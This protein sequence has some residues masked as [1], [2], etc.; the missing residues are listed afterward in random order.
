MKHRLTAVTLSLFMLIS[1]LCISSYALADGPDPTPMATFIKNIPDSDDS[2]YMGTG[3]SWPLEARIE[4]ANESDVGTVTYQWYCA[5]GK[6]PEEADFAPHDASVTADEI[7]ST[8][9]STGNFYRDTTVGGIFT[10]YVVFTNT[11]DNVTTT[12]ESNHRTTYITP[13]VLWAK[14]HNY[15]D[16]TVYYYFQGSPAA[17]L[18]VT[19][20]LRNDTSEYADENNY[21]TIKYQW[22]KSNVASSP[23]VYDDFPFFDESETPAVPGADGEITYQ[24]A[25][26]GL[27]VTHTPV[28]NVV[29][30]FNYFVFVYDELNGAISYTPN[31]L[32]AVIEV[33]PSPVASIT[34]YKTTA[35]V[36]LSVILPEGLSVEPEFKYLL[37]EKDVDPG[38]DPAYNT[39]TLTEA[40]AT[41]T[42]EQ[43]TQQRIYD[44]YL[45]FTDNENTTWPYKARIRAYSD[46][47]G[48][49]GSTTTTGGNAIDAGT[50]DGEIIAGGTM[51]QTSTG[52]TVTIT[53]GSFAAMASH[54][55]QTG[56]SVQINTDTAVVSFDATAVGYIN[57]LAGTDD[58]SLQINQAD[59]SGLSAEDQALIGDRPV[60]DFTLTAGG[61]QVSSF[62][63]GLVTISIPYT[64]AP[65]EQPEAVVVYYIDDAGNLVPVRGAYNAATG[66]VDFP[67]EHFSYY[68]IGYNPLSFTDVAAGDWYYEAITFIAAR[69]ITTGISDTLFAPESAITRGQFIAMLLRAY[70]IAPDTAAGDNFSDA[71]DTYYTGYLAA[72]KRL[73][74]AT[75]MG[76]NLYAPENSLS[77]QDMFTLLYRALDVLGQLPEAAGTADLSAYADGGAVADYAQAAFKSLIAA[78]II[79]DGSDRLRPAAIATRAEMAKVLYSLL[80]V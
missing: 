30:H 63:G 51:T 33:L 4:F 45:V 62:G 3:D 14:D 8:V 1:I 66:T 35:R 58:V 38:V 11:K 17:E 64:L 2:L 73:G 68:A 65:G 34:R 37:V 61:E 41:L 23:L 44:L 32:D 43:L 6:D 29:G 54:S 26:E 10:Y 57:D 80:S 40:A 49:G 7:S 16:S 69:G 75:G 31:V 24:Q 77:R 12:F 56:S 20:G 52:V 13:Q 36:V 67:V 53:D 28:N 59:T 47:G 42:F 46:G 19:L 18:R 48:G 79:T 22:Y 9:F 50:S 39:G 21:G 15:T 25:D 72:A 71:G 55:Q 60:Y 76:G 70:G 78:N 27:T 5:V 74:I